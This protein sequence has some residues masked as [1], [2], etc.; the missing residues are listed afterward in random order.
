MCDDKDKYSNAAKDYMTLDIN[1]YEKDK[2]RAIKSEQRREKYEANWNINKVNLNEIV[3]LFWPNAI[4][5][6]Q[7]GIKFVFKKE[8]YAIECDKVAGYLRIYDRK[9]KKYI[10]LDGSIGNRDETHFKIKK[11]DEI[12]WIIMK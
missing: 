6:T 3:N 2:N 7:S 10:K 4:G 9:L 5:K 8:H 11:R 1:E 12:L